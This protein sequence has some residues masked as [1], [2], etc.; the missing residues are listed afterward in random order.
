MIPRIK[1]ILYT[2]DLTKNSA[3]AFRYAVNS[4]QKHNAQIYLLHVIEKLSPSVEGLLGLHMEQSQIKQLWLEKK[5]EQ[6]KRIHER[7]KEF[8][9]RELQ[10]DPET[11]D[12]LA[13]IIVVEG[14]PASEILEKADELGCDIV[15]MGTHSHGIIAHTFLGSVAQKVLHRTRKPVYIIPI[16]EADT[17]ISFRDF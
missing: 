17:D 7:L 6:I 8:A 9:K 4:A 1:K 5:E 16:P 15:V 12:R 10:N 2:T 13:D 11:M 3:Y 14:D